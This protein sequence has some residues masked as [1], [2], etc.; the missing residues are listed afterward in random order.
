MRFDQIKIKNLI[1][2]SLEDANE[3]S[4]EQCADIAFHMT[5]WIDNLESIIELYEK[6]DF[7]KAEDVNKILLDFLIHAPEHIIAASKLLTGNTVKDI[8]DVGALEK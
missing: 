5:D 4:E 1:E 8:F 6:P 7:Y 2:N 3:F